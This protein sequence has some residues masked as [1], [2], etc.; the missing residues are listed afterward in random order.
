M[1]SKIIF[2]ISFIALSVIF[3]HERIHAQP[4]NNC[5]GFSYLSQQYLDWEVGKNKFEIYCERS[6][7]PQFKISG[8]YSGFKDDLNEDIEVDIRKYVGQISARDLNTVDVSAAISLFSDTKIYAQFN[9]FIG[10][11]FKWGNEFLLDSISYELDGIE[12]HGQ[13]INHNLIGMNT[14]LE[15]TVLIIQ[16]IELKYQLKFHAFKIGYPDINYGLSAGY[17]FNFSKKN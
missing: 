15:F 3:L 7:S 10:P 6:I 5:L 2:H 17:C 16:H 9:L 4:K 8:A 1:L 11:S 13:Q 12:T 14:G